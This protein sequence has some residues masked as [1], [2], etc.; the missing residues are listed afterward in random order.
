VHLVRDHEFVTLVRTAASRLDPDVARLAEGGAARGRAALRRRRSRSIASAGVLAVGAALGI[1]AVAA[2][3]AGPWHQRDRSA[4]GITSQQE[5][6]AGTSP[7]L[8]RDGAARTLTA[9]IGGGAVPGEEWSGPGFVAG[10]ATRSG[11]TYIVVVEYD[12]HCSMK[13]PPSS[14]RTSRTWLRERPGLPEDA[15]QSDSTGTTECLAGAEG[16]STQVTVD[17][18]G[19]PAAPRSEPSLEA[20]GSLA[21]SGAWLR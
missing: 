8:S 12:T 7:A 11:T 19:A 16:D 5:A 1:T 15:G 4:E 18:Y 2:G 10:S 6:D 20:G 9:L 13:V 17:Q 14:A 3:E 21:A